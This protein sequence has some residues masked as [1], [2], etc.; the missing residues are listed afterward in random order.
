MFG[1]ENV[2]IPF[3][4]DFVEIVAPIVPNS[5]C[6]GG[7]WIDRTGGECGY[8]VIAQVEDYQAAIAPAEA[9]DIRSVWKIDREQFGVRIKARH[10]HPADV[11]GAILSLD[12]MSPATEWPWAGPV[13]DWRAKVSTSRVAGI[14]GVVFACKDPLAAAEKW[15]TVLQCDLNQCSRSGEPKGYELAYGSSSVRFVPREGSFADWGLRGDVLLAGFDVR[16]S[17]K[18]AILETA[19]HRLAKVDGESVWLGGVRWSLI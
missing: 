8:M 18:Q 2:L 5:E 10:L 1:L 13:H 11:G 6:A 15:Q 7:R 19:E 17:D 4:D 9:A 3:G 12:Q 14:D 16:T